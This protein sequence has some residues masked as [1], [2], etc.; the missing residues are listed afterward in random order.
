MKNEE[1]FLK[2]SAELIS[3]ARM[4]QKKSKPNRK[5]SPDKQKQHMVNNYMVVKGRVIIAT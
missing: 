4:Q 1:T 3:T 2:Q 5:A